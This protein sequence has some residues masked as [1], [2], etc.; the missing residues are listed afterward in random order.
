MDSNICW[1]QVHIYIRPYGHT[2][3]NNIKLNK[4]ATYSSQGHR[5]ESKN[6]SVTV[7]D[8]KAKP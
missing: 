8:N 7:R 3:V 6:Q 5:Q 1:L 2:I 4:T